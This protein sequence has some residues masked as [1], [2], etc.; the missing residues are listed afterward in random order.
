MIPNCKGCEEEFDMACEYQEENDLHLAS[1]PFGKGHF[2][3]VMVNDNGK[4][5][6]W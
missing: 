3:I 1:W 5:V 4:I 2:H 6:V